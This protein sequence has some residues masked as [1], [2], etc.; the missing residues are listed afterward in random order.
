MTAIAETGSPRLVQRQGGLLSLNVRG[1]AAMHI[2][3]GAII[4]HR[5][6]SALAEIPDPA[7]K[8]TDLI[9]RGYATNEVIVAASAVD[10]DG[11]ALDADGKLLSVN[12]ES[13]IGHDFDTGTGGNEIT[14]DHLGQIAFAY[15]DNT[16]YLTDD[17]GTL[18]P[19]GRIRFVTD[20]GKIALHV[21]DCPIEWRLFGAAGEGG[22]L[23]TEPAAGANLTDAN[24]TIA[25][26]DGNWRKLPAGTLT[27]ARTKTIGTAGAVSGQTITITVF[28]QDFTTT[29]T[30]GGAGAGS[31]E[32]TPN[33]Q[34]VFV[35]YQFD[36]TNWIVKNVG[37]LGEDWIDGTAL[38]DTASTTVQR[39]GRRTSFLLAGTM[40]QN[41]T[42]TLG[43]TGAKKGDI[44]RIVRTSTSAQTA[45]IVNG[46]AG[47]GTLV[48]LPASKV[49]FADARFDGTN[50]QL[51]A[52]GTQ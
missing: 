21:D 28:P 40:S 39:Q 8:R 43:T 26:A 22:I 6:G 5:V 25:I 4:A 19:A 12:V 50:W 23:D 7:A 13:G 31:L 46:G 24:Q 52:C 37:A 35:R 48:T 1:G 29:L 11:R 38:T 42:I 45:A 36:G 30:N 14:R 10:G 41:E 18:S 32:I 51:S 15:D 3:P 49:N 2:Y 33:V 27:A 17:G 34:P 16:L 44:I 9:V 47:A 20:D